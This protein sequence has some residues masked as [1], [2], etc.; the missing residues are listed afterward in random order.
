MNGD[1]LTFGS[2][3][4]LCMMG[5]L[6]FGRAADFFSTWV[7]T[8]KLLLEGNPVAKKL[9]W[10]LGGVVNLALCV[11]LA[12]WPATAL[13]AVTAS[14]LVAAHNFHLAWLMRSMGEEA[15][16]LWFQQ[17]VAEGRLPMQII[18][19]LGETG[20]T[21]LVGVALLCWCPEESKAF[22]IGCGIVAYAFIVLFYTSLSLWRL[23][24]H[25]DSGQ[26]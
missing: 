2:S 26:N 9:G 14:L 25:A 15:Y 13:A 10:K 18:C 11:G 17:R 1:A 20:A 21:A 24:R 7:A 12:F 23:R 8:P 19:L 22:A 3:P 16:G 5:L 4:Y 6:L